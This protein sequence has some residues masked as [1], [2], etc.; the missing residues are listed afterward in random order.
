MTAIVI[1]GG[2]II[3]ASI[4]R[5]LSRYANIDV[6]LIEK[7][8]DV[9][10]GVTKANTGII[11]PGHEDDASVYP[12]RAKFCK[13]GNMLWHQWSKDL[14][15]PIIWPG[16]LMIIFEERE[17]EILQNFLKIGREN[18][19]SDLRIIDKNELLELEPYINQEA[20]GALYAPSAGLIEPWEAVFGLLENAVDNGVKT[21]LNTKVT[22]IRVQEDMIKGVETSNGFIKADIVINAAGLYAD[23]VSKMAGINDVIIQARKGQYYL[24][25]NDVVPNVSRIIHR[26]PNAKT[27]GVYAVKTIE[28]NLM[29]GPTAEDLSNDEKE[30]RGTN[31]KGLDYI[32]DNASGLVNALPSK[33]KVSKIFAGLRPEPPDGKF[34]IKSYQNPWGFINVSGIRSPGLTAAPAIASYVVNTLI[35]I[36]LGISLIEKS[37]WNPLRKRMQRFSTLPDQKKHEIIQDD[38][39][40]GNVVCMCNEVTEGEIIEAVSRIKKLG[41]TVTL[42]GIKFRTTA[43]FGFCQ[44]SFCRSR[45]ALILSKE[46]KTPLWKVTQMGDGTTYGIGDIKVLQSKNKEEEK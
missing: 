3:G 46:L 14:D 34:I 29:I 24:F 26:A 2:G 44:G 37:E 31:Q 41:E 10:W 43:M 7:E 38:S 22:D 16:E 33:G 25:D 13:E 30:D 21:H 39:R 23:I 27:K 4:S 42:D 45:I 17:H 32:W 8:A 19:V 11:H 20:I 15:I 40:Y 36:D 5:I 12:M 35:K 28:G 9:G 18:G 6:H 1:I